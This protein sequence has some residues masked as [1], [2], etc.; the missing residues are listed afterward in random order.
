VLL[1]FKYPK[2]KLLPLI[3]L[4]IIIYALVIVS[5]LA[6]GALW[7][8]FLENRKMAIPKLDLAA[9]PTNID[10]GWWMEYA[11]HYM[12]RSNIQKWK[13][14]T[15]CGSMCQHWSTI[16]APGISCRPIS[17]HETPLKSF[18]SRLF[19]SGQEWDFYTSN[20]TF[21]MTWGT[22]NLPLKF[23]FVPMIAQLSDNALI[24][25]NQTGPIQ[26]QL[27][28][29]HDKEYGASFDERG[30]SLQSSRDG[31]TP[32]CV[33]TS[34]TSLSIDCSRYASAATNL[35]LGFIKNFVG[36]AG[37]NTSGKRPNRQQFFPL[38][39]ILSYDISTENQTISL[40]SPYEPDSH[41]LLS[42]AVENTFTA[43]VLGAL[44]QSD[45][46]EQLFTQVDAWD[47]WG[48]YAPNLWMA[49]GPAL[50]LVLLVGLC[51]LRW[52]RQSD[53]VREKKFSSF[54]IATRTKD[55]DAVCAQRS[56]GVMSTKLRHD[57]QTGHFL[58][59]DDG[60]ADDLSYNPG[61]Y[62]NFQ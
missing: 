19:E 13:W 2:L 4:A 61:G 58:V 32:N 59:Q 5:V 27:C 50:F 44:M 46:T 16:Q 43:V 41:W 62:P 10:I 6:P 18:D 37:W 9:L 12:R 21:E 52:S 24:S 33:W 20:S 49:Y 25:V 45:Q 48:F 14:T 54:L 11:K 60:K 38:Q 55:L 31:F 15:E 7:I 22:N 42:E 26:G 23:S 34:N 3:A 17:E 29:F 56:E 28:E 51:G 1:L 57:V 30:V 8:G 53:I 39:N 36:T 35:S 40:K 47:K